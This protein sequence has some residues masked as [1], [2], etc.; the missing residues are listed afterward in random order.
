MRYRVRTWGALRELAGLLHV[1]CNACKRDRYLQA[2]E[3]AH[4][5]GD[6]RPIADIT[7]RCNLCDSRDVTLHGYAS[8]N[9]GE[10]KRYQ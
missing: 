3:I 10:N 8:V 4:R 1:H 9:I 5:A 6:Y 2:A 7:F